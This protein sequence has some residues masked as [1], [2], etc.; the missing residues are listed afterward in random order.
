VAGETPL[1]LASQDELTEV[2]LEYDTGPS[3]RDSMDVD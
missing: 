2:T 3:S 1:H